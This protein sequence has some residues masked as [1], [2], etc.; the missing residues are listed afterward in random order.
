MIFVHE[1]RD[2]LENSLLQ[3]RVLGFNPCKNS[4]LAYFSSVSIHFEDHLWIFFLSLW[5]LHGFACRF[6]DLRVCSTHCPKRQTIRVY[7]FN[8]LSRISRQHTTLSPTDVQS[9][10]CIHVFTWTT[11]FFTNSIQFKSF[12]SRIYLENFQSGL[13]YSIY[14]NE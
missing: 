8:H 2:R 5:L 11:E 4:V 6:P 13:V 12:F 10:K 1:K 14:F 7:G 9:N 3:G